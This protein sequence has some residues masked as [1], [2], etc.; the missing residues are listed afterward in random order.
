M[1]TVL[2]NTSAGDI[3]LELDETKAP[4]TV[5]NFVD[6]VRAGHYTDTVFHRVIPNFMIQGGGLTADMSQKPAPNR[7]ENEAKNGLRNEKYTVAMAR[8]S[9]P[10]SA[11]A[12]F[13]INTSD[14]GFLNYPGQDGWGYAVFGKVVA[15]ADVVDAIGAVPTTSRGG[16][17]DV[18]KE[19]VTILSA[20][21]V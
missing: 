20:Q 14:N 7:V 4:K 6:Y 5:A 19:A 21:V 16:H 3:T 12:Q 2:L 15:G 8:T 18:P 17:R 13:F 1:T 11:S 9:D 10:H